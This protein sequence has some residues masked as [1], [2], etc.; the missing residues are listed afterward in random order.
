MFFCSVIRDVNLYLITIYF[1]LF[2]KGLTDKV[3][4]VTSK[5]CYYSQLDHPGP[6]NWT[7]P[8]LMK[9]A[10]NAANSVAVGDKVIESTF[11]ILMF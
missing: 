3:E 7:G 6:Q 8:V 4:S 5:E 10:R 11:K 2:N 1:F 9:L